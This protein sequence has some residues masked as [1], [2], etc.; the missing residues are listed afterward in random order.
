LL[1][2]RE[3]EVLELLARRCSAREIARALRVSQATVKTH[4]QRIYDKLGVHKR[5]DLALYAA[6]IAG[7]AGR[8]GVEPV[9]G[10]REALPFRRVRWEGRE[11]DSAVVIDFCQALGV[12][13]WL[14]RGA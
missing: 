2:A 12:R 5:R 11:R 14:G 4:T 8:E 9:I 1:T 13:R 10:V 6:E 3:S 7:V